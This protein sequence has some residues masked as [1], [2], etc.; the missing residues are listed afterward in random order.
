MNAASSETLQQLA[1]EITAEYN[2]ELNSGPTQELY[3]TITDHSRNDTVAKDAAVAAINNAEISRRFA[4]RQL[5]QIDDTT[6][7]RKL[8]DEGKV[9][10]QIW[11]LRGGWKSP[12]SHARA[13]LN[14]A[15][16]A[17]NARFGRFRRVERLV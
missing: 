17:A 1:A 14:G 4:R 3:D 15:A 10:T 11:I 6:S 12:G 13:G 16:E 9:I 5:Q 2:K 8:G 7:N